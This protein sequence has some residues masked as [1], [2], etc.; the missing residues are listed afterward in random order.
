MKNCGQFVINHKVKRFFGNF[1][2]I[3]VWSIF[4]A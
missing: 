3:E 4:Y 2:K 1:S